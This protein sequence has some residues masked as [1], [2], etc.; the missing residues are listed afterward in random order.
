[1]VLW[2]KKEARR[3]EKSQFAY[4]P[5]I[6]HLFEVLELNFMELNLSEPTLTSFVSI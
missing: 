6:C 3:S 1:M 4:F 5:Y 2:G